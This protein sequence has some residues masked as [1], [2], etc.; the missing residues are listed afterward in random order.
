MNYPFTTESI[1]T[2]DF[3]I[4]QRCNILSNENNFNNKLWQKG[5]QWR[6]TFLDRIAVTAR[7]ER[8]ADPIPHRRNFRESSFKYRKVT[9]HNQPRILGLTHYS[10]A[11]IQA[12]CDAL[13]TLGRPDLTEAAS[14]SSV[15]VQAY[16]ETCDTKA[17]VLEE[18]LLSSNLSRLAEKD[19]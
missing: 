13:C 18:I 17:K 4:L 14:D 11:F 3:H 16:K 12:R 15:W 8:T 2:G 1:I 6:E 5:S 19:T 7:T 9:L 10:Q